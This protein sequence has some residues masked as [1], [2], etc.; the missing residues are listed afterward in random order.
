[1]FDHRFMRVGHYTVTY[2]M[3]C[4]QV[5]GKIMYTGSS[6]MTARSWV[7]EF[8]DCTR[9]YKGH[10]HTVSCIRFHKGFSKYSILTSFSPF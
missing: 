5:V 1:M 9:V 3:S 7:T 8:G 10:Q 6:D 2:L 4:L